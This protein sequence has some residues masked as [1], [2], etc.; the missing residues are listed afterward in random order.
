M[1]MNTID[2]INETLRRRDLPDA[3]HDYLQ[4]VFVALSVKAARE[5]PQPLTLDEL[6]PKTC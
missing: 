4:A 3:D 6:G 1:E 5:N 2:A